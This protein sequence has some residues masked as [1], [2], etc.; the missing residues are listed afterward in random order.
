[1]IPP[2]V[3]Q[4]KA[5]AAKYAA[6]HPPLVPNEILAVIWSESTGN[7]DAVNPSDPSYGLM[8]ITMPIAKA[9]GGITDSQQLFDPELNI[10][11]GSSFVAHLKKM[12]S[13]HFPTTWIAGYNEGEGNLMR[14]RPDLSYVAAFDSHMAELNDEETST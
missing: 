11:A 10:M 14:G 1:M 4:W 9:F 12:Y 7:P 5:L 2:S 8:Q 13:H 6:L 3:L